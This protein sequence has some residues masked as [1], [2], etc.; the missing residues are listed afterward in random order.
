VLE[1]TDIDMSRLH[2]VTDAS[3]Y[4]E[5]KGVASY[6]DLV[7]PEGPVS[8]LAAWTYRSPVPAYA[9]LRDHIAFYPGRVEACWLDDERVLAQEGDFYGGWVTADITGPFKGG[10]GTRGW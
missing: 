8:G 4:C 2:E 7:D 9:A 1:A 6:F 10:P 3:T 5:F